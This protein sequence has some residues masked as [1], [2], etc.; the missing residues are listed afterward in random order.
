M[1][2]SKLTM[3]GTDW[4]L[5]IILSVLWGGS[6]FF[7]KIALDAFPPLT[8]AFLRVAIAAIIL[9]I[10]VRAMG[11]LQLPDRET[12]P[13]Y[14]L[15]AIINNVLP[16]TLIFWGQ[17]HITSGLASILNA[18]TPLFGVIVAHLATDDDRL[19]A[20][21]A[22]G[23]GIGFAGVVIMLGPDLLGEIGTNLAA[24]LAC[25]SAALLYAVS[26][27]YARRFRGTPPM[28]V[29]AS[30]M[31]A[32]TVMLLP[33]ALFIDCPWTLP[34]PSIRA[35]GAVIGL[36]AL[37]TA[38]AYLIYYR[39]LARAGATNLLLVTFLIPVSAILLGV[40]VLNEALVF[41]Q[42][43]GMAAIAAGLA[44]ID[45]RPARWLARAFGARP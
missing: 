38:L 15:V 9:L 17:T 31:C 37:S 11:L 28:V 44:A 21:R 29:S 6:F 33:L 18:T 39:V 20:A 22:T 27:V 10:V 40:L 36:A 2:P 16:F 7:A 41:R 24:Q 35:A 43:V 13:S 42:L 8:L 5:L 19:N 34:A 1:P 45:G 30:Q 12:W 14:V 32:S 3:S 23:L 26:G 25:L 4:I